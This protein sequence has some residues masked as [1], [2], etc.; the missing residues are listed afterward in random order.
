MGDWWS[1]HPDLEGIARRGRGEIEDEAVSAEQDTELLRKRRRSLIDVCFEWM[2]RGDL[3]TVA[4][5]GTHFEGQ[6]MAA[7]NDLIILQTKTIGVSV[8][9]AAVSYVRSE[10][11]GTFSGNTGERSASSFRAQLGRFEVDAIPVRLV[12]G[13]GQFDLIAVIEASTDDHLLVRDKRGLEW[14]L[15]RSQV[16]YAIP[17]SSESP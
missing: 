6:L 17:A 8:D 7:V 4:V 12:G 11:P 3:V 10:R 5:A 14:A 13:T 15:P 1:D 16:G 2:S 9:V